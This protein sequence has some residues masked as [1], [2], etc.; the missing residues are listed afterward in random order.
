MKIKKINPPR[1]FY[2]TND[3]DLCLKDT[4]HISVEDGETYVVNSKIIF[5]VNSWGF[6]INNNLD[7]NFY[8][9]GSKITDHLIH[10]LNKKKLKTYCKKEKQ[11]TISISKFLANQK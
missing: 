1:K 10:V 7:K 11:K 2:P 4:L 8:F 5:S 3:K 6:K 9:M